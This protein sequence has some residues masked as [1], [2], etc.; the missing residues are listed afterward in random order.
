MQN[1]CRGSRRPAIPRINLRRAKSRAV[2]RRPCRH[3]SRQLNKLSCMHLNVHVCITHACVESD[4][5]VISSTKLRHGFYLIKYSWKICTFGYVHTSTVGRNSVVT[6]I[7]ISIDDAGHMHVC[8]STNKD[9]RST[10][11]SKPA[12]T[13]IRQAWKISDCASPRPDMLEGFASPRGLTLSGS[14]YTRSPSELS[15]KSH[16]STWTLRL[17]YFTWP[18]IKLSHALI[19]FS[20]YSSTFIYLHDVSLSCFLHVYSPNDFHSCIPS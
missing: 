18:R 8:I 2:S 9:S 19:F 11:P 16:P 7:T 4:S 20:K 3:A 14:D 15:S 6:L 13:Y 5:G 12:F 1:H 17:I 10:P